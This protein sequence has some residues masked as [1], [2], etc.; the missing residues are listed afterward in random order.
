MKPG[1]VTVQL[2]VSALAE[3]GNDTQHW[4]EGGEREER[5]RRE[6]GEREIKGHINQVDILQSARVLRLQLF[7]RIAT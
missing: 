7:E 3:L 2:Q 1:S 6:G 4:R 5:G